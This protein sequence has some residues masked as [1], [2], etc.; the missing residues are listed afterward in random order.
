MPNKSDIDWDRMKSNSHS[1]L[2]QID[3]WFLGFVI[4]VRHGLLEDNS[5]SFKPTKAG[6][7]IGILLTTEQLH[8]IEAVYFAKKGFEQDF[9]ETTLPN[10]VIRFA[11]DYAFAGLRK[12][13]DHYNRL[14]D[15]G[16]AFAKAIEESPES[17]SGLQ[18]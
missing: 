17:D 1:S 6:E 15:L 9:D 10:K 5:T 7:N 18:L 11:H 12:L 4:G 2:R 3:L 16:I 13:V 8:L 14:G